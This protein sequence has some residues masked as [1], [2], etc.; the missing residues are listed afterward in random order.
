MVETVRK[1]KAAGRIGEEPNDCII[2]LFH[3]FHEDQNHE[4]I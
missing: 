3:T 4:P 2:Y 1:S